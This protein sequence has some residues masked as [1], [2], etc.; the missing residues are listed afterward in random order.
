[1]EVTSLW[2]MS[3]WTLL[4]VMLLSSP[5]T[6]P[7]RR[8]VRAIVAAA[9]ALPPV[10]VAAAPVI[11]IALHRDIIPSD[12]V[13]VRLLAERVAHEWRR[14]S[15]RPLRMIGGEG[16]LA[17][18]VAFYSPGRVSAFPDFNR[19]LAPWADPARLRRE[20]MAV[21]CRASVR[22]VIPSGLTLQAGPRIE[23]DIRPDGFG[24]AGA[25]GRYVILIAP[26]Q[27]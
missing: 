23:I 26:P 6:M 11:A 5:L 15:D 7:H 4:P 3:A 17:Y 27:P 24:R 18:G 14:A 9:I 16:D 12:T 22:C 10:A 8:A 2:S 21:V 1:V 19:T 20:G 25:P 13:P